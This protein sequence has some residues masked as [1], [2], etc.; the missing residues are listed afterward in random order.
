M[1]GSVPSQGRAFATHTAS[2]RRGSWFFAPLALSA[3]RRSGC[4]RVMSCSTG[5][6]VGRRTYGKLKHMDEDG[7]WETSPTA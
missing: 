4:D 7:S 3:W 2:A 6:E 1:G 5:Q